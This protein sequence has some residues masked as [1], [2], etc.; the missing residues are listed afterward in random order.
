VANRI[1]R[2]KVK[3]I[4]IKSTEVEIKEKLIPGVRSLGCG[5]NVFSAEYADAN[6]LT[7]R[8]FNLGQMEQE[9]VN[10][11]LYKR[12][13]RVSYLPLEGSEHKIIAGLTIEEYQKELTISAGIKGKYGLFKGSVDTNFKT[14]EKSRSEHSFVTVYD[15]IKKWRL[16]ITFSRPRDLLNILL[17]KVREDLNDET[18]EA[19]DLFNV[20]G[21]HF[22]TGIIVGAR[23]NYS[24]SVIKNTFEK[25]EELKIAAEASYG[26]L[27]EAK[28]KVENKE[29]IKKFNDNSGSHI[30]T[31]GGNSSLAYQIEN[32]DYKEWAESTDERP[33]FIDYAENGIHPIWEL[34]NEDRRDYLKKAYEK[35]EEEHKPH[36]PEVQERVWGIAPN[37]TIWTLDGHDGTWQNIEGVLKQVSVASSGR[38]W[39]VS[40]DDRVWTRDGVDGK[41]DEPDYRAR[42]KWVSTNIDDRV[43]G[44]NADNQVFTRDGVDGTWQVIEGLLTQLSVADDGRV[45][46]VAPNGTIWTRDGVDGIWQNIEGG[47]KQISVADGGRVWGVDSNN[48]VWTRDGVDGEWQ[49]IK[50]QLLKQVSVARNGH[51]WGVTERNQ[52]WMRYGVDGTWTQIEGRDLK[53]ISIA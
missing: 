30:W 37:G 42:M 45:W 2:V 50:D 29:K 39:G 5:V 19:E 43:W 22:L 31:I 26:D 14:S 17:P 3:P 1:E 33:V 24:S 32:G 53:Q 28:G 52:V 21:T 34:C 16:Q 8:L 41:W 48:Q 27:I 15:L 25:V 9:N 47:L 4:K 35:L 13:K 40:S 18:F 36:I 38:V 51:V 23:A 7:Q 46:G 11:E 44:V 49:E 10:D 20:Y 12:P 6:G